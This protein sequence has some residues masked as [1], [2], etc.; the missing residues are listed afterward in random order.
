MFARAYH[1][2]AVQRL[3]DAHVRSAVT[4]A[5]TYPAFSA[6]RTGGDPWWHISVEYRCAFLIEH[7]DIDPNDVPYDMNG[8]YPVVDDGSQHRY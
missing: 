1:R 6:P 4:L 7:A 2:Q 5:T 3:G 8:A